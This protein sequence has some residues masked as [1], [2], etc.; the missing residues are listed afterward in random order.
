MI[1][2][3]VARNL[4]SLIKGARRV[5]V[6]G[7]KRIF[8][9]KRFPRLMGK[10]LDDLAVAL[11]K[12]ANPG[13]LGST[14]T[15]LAGK[16]IHTLAVGVLPDEVSRHNSPSRAESIRRVVSELPG[17]RGKTAIIVVL[18]D[19]SHILAAMNA[20]GRAYPTFTRKTGSAP[21]ERV[22]VFAVDHDG[23]PIEIP[24]IA[25]LT[26]DTTRACAELVDTPPTDLNPEAYGERAHAML[27]ELPNVEVEEIVG[28]DLLEHGLGGIHAVGR[29]A[30]KPP[31][32]IVAT[33]MPA[34]PSGTHIA[35]VGKG[36]VYDTGG[37]NLKV[38][39]NMYTMK[40]DMGGSAAVL[41]AFCVLAQSACRHQV[42][43]ILCIAENAIGPNAYKPDDVLTMHSGKTV[44]INNT[45]AEGR[46]LLADGVSWATHELGC[47]IVF[48][49]ATL[50]GAQLISLGVLHA[51]ICCNDDALEATVLAAGKSSGD[52]CHPLLF[53]PEFLKSEFRSTIAD[54]RNSVSNRMNAQTS[55]AGQFVYNHMEDS[56]ARWCHVDLAGPAFPKDRGTGYGV[57]LL[58]QAILALEA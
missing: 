24:D 43:L 35:L 6:V 49:A 52:L 37:L 58:S 53:A 56:K 36:V 31:R 11:S 55:C 9:P 25:K 17:G 1:E 21:K 26:M 18:D 3:A 7:P 2:I 28:D 20:I 23:R 42:T 54:M 22:Q 41:G 13:L 8:T 44:E 32:M 40:C 51:G 48:D 5:A 19:P 10:R 30:V 16:D 46:L 34:E 50:T 12:E 38:G 57:A 47:D 14:A 29:C 33:Y 39:G 45:D 15:T 4:K 27:A